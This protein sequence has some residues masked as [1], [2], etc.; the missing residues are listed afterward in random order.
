[1]SDR[2]YLTAMIAITLVGSYFSILFGSWLGGEV[3]PGWSWVQR[4]RVVWVR[5]DYHPMPADRFHLTII[6]DSNYESE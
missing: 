4:A 5:H 2:A 1:M 3:L 6:N